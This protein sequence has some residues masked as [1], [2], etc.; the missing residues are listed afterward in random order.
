MQ[1]WS[2]KFEVIIVVAKKI[3]VLLDVARPVVS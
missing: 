2:V 3:Q 1:L